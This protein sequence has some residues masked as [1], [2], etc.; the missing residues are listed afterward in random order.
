MKIPLPQR[1][2]PIDVDYI[3]QIIN[4]LNTLTNQVSSTSTTLS[5]VDNGINGIKES[6]TSNLRLYSSTKNVKKGSVTASSNESWFV[7]FNP[8][9]LY[10]PIV[11]AT[12]V[13][14]NASTAGNNIVSVIKNVTT[15]RVD[16][17]IIFNT[18]GT[19]DVN[20]NVIAVGTT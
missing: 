3:Y 6:T 18:S 1:G 16:G 11:V 9:F 5:S 13:N 2:Q 17:N 4:Q 20:I 10:I 14:N 12:I 8:Q 7:D 19:I 15:S